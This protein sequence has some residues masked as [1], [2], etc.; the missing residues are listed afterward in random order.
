MDVHLESES[1]VRLAGTGSF[2][3]PT[4]VTNAELFELDT[5]RAAFDVGRAR[6]ALRGVENPATLSEVE[7]FDAW[8]RQVTGIEERRVVKG[9]DLTTE[10]MAAEAARLALG[11]AGIEAADLDLILISSVTPAE[12][13]PNMACTVGNQLGAPAV[14]GYELNAA[15][16][17]FMHGLATGRAFMA[18]GAARNVLVV[19]ADSLSHITNYS[20]P[21]TAVLFADGAGAAVLS[22]E[23]GG[24]RIVGLPNLTA[25]YS[26]DSLN[27]GGQGWIVPGLRDDRLSMGGGANVLRTAI[28]SMSEVAR[29]ALESAGLS[30]DDVDIVIPHQANL[31]ITH[32]LER[33]LR[34]AKGRVIHNIQRLGNMSAATV[35]VTLDELLAGLHGP[36][37]DP[38]TIVCT[39]VGGG[40][41]SGAVVIVWEGGSVA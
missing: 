25:D 31:R 10:D 6:G 29:G 9:T 1:Q 23:T 20:D 30:W 11:R 22:T 21:T 12:E 27:L 35:A 8:A 18:S 34:L 16:A 41:A 26:P 4:R 33:S 28:Q 36:I 24:G 39:A 7:V 13:V 40:Y 14:A 37:P 2:L 38:A 19:S 32:G 5:I 3:P 17:G 15:C